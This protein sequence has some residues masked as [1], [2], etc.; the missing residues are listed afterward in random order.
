MY[1]M[2]CRDAA[3]YCVHCSSAGTVG[4]RIKRVAGKMDLSRTAFN[5]VFS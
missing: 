1:H 3:M 4:E 2:V 5:I